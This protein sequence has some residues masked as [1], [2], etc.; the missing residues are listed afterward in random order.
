MLD[1]QL[2][3]SPVYQQL[4]DRLR[5]ALARDYNCG[6]R[7]LTKREIAQRFEV[8]RATANK[9]LASLAI[10]DQRNSNFVNETK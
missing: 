10:D 4:N 3:Q 7:F 6:D 2:Q 8:S 9:A 5:S 1:T